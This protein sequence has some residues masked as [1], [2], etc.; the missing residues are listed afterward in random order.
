MRPGLGSKP[1]ASA[2]ARAGA[3]SLPEISRQLA[4]VTNQIG[5]AL[6]EA[7]VPAGSNIECIGDFLGVLVP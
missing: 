1:D 4:A 5:M 6:D 7:G 3:A 2:K